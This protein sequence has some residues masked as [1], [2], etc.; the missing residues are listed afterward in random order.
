MIKFPAPSLEGLRINTQPNHRVRWRQKEGGA[1][2]YRAG[3][4]EAPVLRQPGAQRGGGWGGQRRRCQY[5]ISGCH[6]VLAKLS[7]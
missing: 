6:L 1:Q 2:D 3:Y 4:L 7:K 5:S